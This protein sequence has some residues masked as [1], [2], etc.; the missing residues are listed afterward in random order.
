LLIGERWRKNAASKATRP[1][2]T[3]LGLVVD[4]E[5]NARTLQRFN[6]MQA[7]ARKLRPGR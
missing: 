4:R 2:Y 3:G 7:Q 5:L 6:V 1:L